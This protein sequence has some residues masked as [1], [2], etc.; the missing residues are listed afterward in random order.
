MPIETIPINATGTTIS[1]LSS[2]SSWW[3]TFAVF[4]GMLLTIFLFSK[5]IRQFFYGAIVTGGLFGIYKFS[6]W[7]GVSTVENNINPLKW[8]C[9]IVGFIAI[10]I[11]IGRLLQRLKFVKNLEKKLK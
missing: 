7:I 3:I 1:A 11:I 9:Y 4:I 2:T 8:T 6:R 5:N 10:S